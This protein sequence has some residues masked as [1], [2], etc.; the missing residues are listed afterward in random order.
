MQLCCSSVGGR[1]TLLLLLLTAHICSVECCM[2]C[3]TCGGRQSSSVLCNALLVV[4]HLRQSVPLCVWR[5]CNETCRLVKL[6]A[7]CTRVHAAVGTLG[8]DDQLLVLETGQFHLA[9][10]PPCRQYSSLLTLWASVGCGWSCFLTVRPKQ[11]GCCNVRQCAMLLQLLWPACFCKT[12]LPWRTVRVCGAWRACH[13][14]AEVAS[15]E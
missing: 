12:V 15:L 13:L 10:S 2:I 5:L 3:I 6:T 9:T 4:A 8:V 11:V 1:L 14:G 7:A